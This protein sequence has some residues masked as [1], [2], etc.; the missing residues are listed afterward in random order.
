M[1]PDNIALLKLSILNASNILYKTNNLT[2]KQVSKLTN[3]QKYI[4]LSITLTYLVNR[5]CDLTT[6]YYNVSE[7]D[8]WKK[9][10][11]KNSETEFTQ[12]ILIKLVEIPPSLLIGRADFNQS[13]QF[14]VPVLFIGYLRSGEVSADAFDSAFAQNSENIL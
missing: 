14:C 10:I 8:V 6:F 7:L 9:A 2:I 5:P 12:E 1:N 13:V 4:L 3:H 11:V